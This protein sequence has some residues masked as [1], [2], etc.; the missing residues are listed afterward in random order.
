MNLAREYGSAVDAARF[1]LALGR[2]RQFS[3]NYEAAVRALAPAADVFQ[4]AGLVLDELTA[5]GMLAACGWSAGDKATAAAQSDLVG[6]LLARHGRSD[7][8]QPTAVADYV[9]ALA[10]S[11]PLPGRPHRLI[12]S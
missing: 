3:A 6:Q 9:C 2:A 12:T 1:G 8:R 5:R 10:R 4:T 7:T 11:G